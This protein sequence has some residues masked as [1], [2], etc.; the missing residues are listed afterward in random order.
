[1][2]AARGYLVEVLLKREVERVSLWRKTIDRFHFL[3]ARGYLLLLWRGRVCW[4]S[5]S[6]VSLS[7][8]LCGFMSISQPASCTSTS[9]RSHQ[10]SKASLWVLPADFGSQSSQLISLSS[11]LNWISNQPFTLHYWENCSTDSSVYLVKWVWYVCNKCMYIFRWESV[12]AGVVR[13]YVCILTGCLAG[14]LDNPNSLHECTNQN[15]KTVGRRRLCQW[16][17]L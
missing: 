7:L 13:T 8:S 17:T 4:E 15:L 2:N 6:K 3:V 12:S 14:W 5:E 9:I 16:G 1:M 11:T 10:L